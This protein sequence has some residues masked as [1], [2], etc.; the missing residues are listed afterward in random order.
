M[1]KYAYYAAYC[2]YFMNK[3]YIFLLFIKSENMTKIFKKLLTMFLFTAII[4]L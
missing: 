1:H 2:E 4:S 3:M